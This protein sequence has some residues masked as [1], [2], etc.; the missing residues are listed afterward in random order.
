MKDVFDLSDNAR[1]IFNDLYSFQGESIGQ[2]FERVS[3]EFSTNKE[4]KKTAYDL[5]ADGIWRPNTPVFLNAG[6]DH[7]VFSACYVVGL[8]DSMNSIYD[9]AD[10]CRKIFQFGAGVGI[11]IGNL[12][13][14]EA[15]IYEGNKEKLP[16][17]KSSGPI[18]FMKLYDAVGET[19]KSGGR[20]RRAAILCSM[21]VW[22]PD[23]T[24]F[25]NCK[26]IDGRLASMNISVAI[27]DKFMESLEDSIPFDLI[28]PYDGE[29]VGMVNPR[30][31]WD[32]IVEMAWKTA[33]PG[34]LFI[35]NINKYNTL[36][37]KILVNC[38]NPCGEQPLQPFNACNLSAINIFKFV[39]GINGDF[40]WDGLYQTTYKVMKLMDNLIDTMDFPDDDDILGRQRFRENTLKY[41]PVGVGPMGMS[42]AMF[43]LGLRYDGADGR[44]FASEVMRIMTKACVD[45]S[46][47]IAKEMGPFHDYEFFKEDVERIISEHVGNDEDTMK[48]VKEYGVRNCQFTTCQPTGTTALSCDASYGIEPCF[49]LVFQKNLI[50]G[51]R[52]IVANPIF[53]KKFKHEDWFTEDLLERIFNNGGSLKGL[54]NIPKEVKRI[55]VTAHDI[56]YK[57]RIDMQAALQEFCSTAISSTINLPKETTVEEVSEIYKYSYER[58]LK[59]ITIYRDG[60]KLDQPVTFTSEKKKKKGPFERPKTLD[61]KTHYLETGNGKM[62]V[63][64]SSASGKPVEVFFNLGKSGQILNT[65]TEALGRTISI[66]LQNGVPI[67]EI[68]KTLENINSDKMVWWRFEDNDKK[69]TQILSIPDGVSKLLKRYY[70]GKVYQGELS[71]EICEKCGNSMTAIEG[72]FNCPACG[73]SKCS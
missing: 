28:S 39:K 61:S 13:Q 2:T 12:R 35:D 54:H 64:V 38:T 33:D 11:P 47:Q 18:T 10:V 4:E 50:S 55:F 43:A 22:H 8:E 34:I 37:K 68:S 27:T 19:T 65:L 6:T 58:G 51:D 62:Y 49:G 25:I 1:K 41:R 32:N 21:P 40:D 45:Q 59:G 72:C 14:K 60:S 23:I 63:T 57:D 5:L 20:V 9:I 53:E 15:Y 42:D 52:M 73:H 31:V 44:K 48:L 71:A 70:S 56:K 66:G 69:P 36:A 17:G 30:D 26:E 16:E 7:K 46:V 24:E 29:V 67:E 3:N